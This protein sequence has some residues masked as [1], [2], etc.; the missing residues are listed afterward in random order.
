MYAAMDGEKYDTKLCYI[1]RGGKWWLL[2]EWVDNLSR[3]GGVQLL[4][5]PGSS[6]FMT[7]PGNG[8]LHVDVILPMLHGKNGEDG[9][10]QGLAKIAHIPIAG[11]SLLG[12]AVTIN[13]DLTKR[14][15]QQAGIPVVEWRTWYTHDSSPS[16]DEICEVLG[17]VVI[18][19]PA[20]A[21]SSMGVSKVRSREEYEVA[22]E[23]ASRHDTIV[24]IERA[25][26]GIEVQI[27]LLGKGRVEM[28][29]ICEIESV[30]D[31]HDFDDKYDENSSAQFHIPARLS[32]E[33]TER[34]KRYAADAYHLTRCDGM[35]RIDF[36]VVND[37][38]EY[39][40]EINSIPGFTN[41]SVYPK[42]WRAAGVHYPAL[43]DELIRNALK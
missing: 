15:L 32:P 38:T 4:L 20:N 9:T 29:E 19:K 6:S 1:D 41:V 35:A 22:L 36:F 43:I 24:L 31:F 5:A 42:L 34:I 18:V 26:N 16:Y 2:D 37:T 11:P 21:G 27:A 28:T 12:A 7:I 25:I 30:A 14:V 39:V 33:Q 13:K 8:V 3:H 10:V 40:N 23:V 17:E